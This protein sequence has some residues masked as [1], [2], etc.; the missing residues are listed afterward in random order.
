MSFKRN[1]ENGY[2]VMKTAITAKGN[3]I[4]AEFDLRFGRSA[5]FCLIDQ[6]SDQIE[7]IENPYSEL[8]ENAGVK[9]T[10]K[11]ISLGVAKVI[12]GDFGPKAQ[13]L[14]EQN[15]IQMVIF[16]DDR[17]SIADLLGLLRK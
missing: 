14:L 11:L 3:K 15:H 8:S 16:P 6:D 7:F 4:K 2:H 10:E 9:V 5:Y 17:Q 13:E 1:N 12:S